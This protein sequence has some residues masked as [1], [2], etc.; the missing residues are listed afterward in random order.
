MK[1]YVES[2]Q[3]DKKKKKKDKSSAKSKVTKRDLGL[4][5]NAKV[6]ME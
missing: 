2:K 6:I 4:T 3:E 5:E 1:Q